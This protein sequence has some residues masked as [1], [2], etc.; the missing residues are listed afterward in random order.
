M[1]DEEVRFTTVDFEGVGQTT[2]RPFSF[3]LLLKQARIAAVI[4]RAQRD[5]SKDT[6]ALGMSRQ[7]AIALYCGLVDFLTLT[8]EPLPCRPSLSSSNPAMN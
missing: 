7:D 8:G 1:S 4:G 3:L 2:S 5:G 6:F